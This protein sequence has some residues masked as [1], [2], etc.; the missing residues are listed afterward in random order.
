MNCLYCDEGTEVINSRLQKRS[1]A[2]WR[3]RRCQKCKN[4]FSTIER[5]ELAQA[6]RVELTDGKLAPFDRDKLYISIYNC[7]KHRTSPVSDATELTNTIIYTLTKSNNVIFSHKS[8]AQTT[9]TILELFDNVAGMQYGAY[10]K[11]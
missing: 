2:I 11:A 3:R 8:I 4:V 9:Q 10:H 6:V 5:V 1:N 7:L